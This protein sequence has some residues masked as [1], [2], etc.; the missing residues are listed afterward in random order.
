M[1]HFEGALL[2]KSILKKH[3]LS[4]FSIFSFNNTTEYF[5]FKS[6]NQDTY[7]QHSHPDCPLPLCYIIVT[8]NSITRC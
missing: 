5:S 8:K 6:I 4:V 3:D 2:K 7:E 1:S